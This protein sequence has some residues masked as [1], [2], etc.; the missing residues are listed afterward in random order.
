MI[1]KKKPA[2]KERSP[3]MSDHVRREHAEE[4]FT[5][6]PFPGGRMILLFTGIAVVAYPLLSLYAFRRDPFVFTIVES[7]LAPGSFFYITAAGIAV[8]GI[9]RLVLPS[10]SP[11]QQASNLGKDR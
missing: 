9:A 8:T 2:G 7:K 6:R 1:V 4:N 11:I 5:E 3:D 10:K